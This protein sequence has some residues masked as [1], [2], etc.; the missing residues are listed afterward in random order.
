MASSPEAFEDESDGSGN[1][2]NLRMNNWNIQ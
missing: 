1:V 2:D